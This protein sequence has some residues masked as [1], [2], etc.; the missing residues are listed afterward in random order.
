M[1]S[2]TH[3]GPLLQKY[4]RPGSGHHD[5]VQECAG[6]Q[7]GRIAGNEFNSSRVRLNLIHE[8]VLVKCKNSR[9]PGKASPSWLPF[10]F[11]RVDPQTREPLPQIYEDSIVLQSVFTNARERLEQDGNLPSPT[12]SDE[13]EQLDDDE[14]D[15][16][17]AGG[18]STKKRGRGPDKKV[19]APVR[20]AF[21]LF[22]VV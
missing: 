15:P 21:L 19:R 7:H 11:V 4:R 3:Q 5:T 2:E 22:V 12:Q 1:I 6:V 8:H 20:V 9:H 14:D 17:A 16:D 18:A 10:A 13:D